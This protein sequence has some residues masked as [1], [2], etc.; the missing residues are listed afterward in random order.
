LTPVGSEAY[1]REVR[2]AR[3]NLLYA[4]PVPLLVGLALRSWRLIP[5]DTAE[6]LAHTVTRPPLYPIFL[7]LMR[8][9][10][11]SHF[12]AGTAVVQQ[13]LGAGAAYWLA[14]RMSTRLELGRA[15]LALYYALLLPGVDLALVIG[16]ESISYSLFL[17]MSA[18]F[19]DA[20]YEPTTRRL[21]MPLVFA[22]LAIMTRA[23]FLFTLPVLA[24]GLLFAARQRSG[25]ATAMLILYAVGLLAAEN[26]AVKA[27]NYATNR[28]F[29]AAPVTGIQLLTM[30]TYVL[31]HDDLSLFA[32][33]DDRRYMSTV[34]QL[35]S[36]HRLLYENKPSGD[37][38]T[39]H[40]Y[41]SYAFICYDVLADTWA[42]QFA[43]RRF[44]RELQGRSLTPDQLVALDRYM[45]HLSSILVRHHPIRYATLV[46]KCWY[47]YSGLF[48]LFVTVAFVIALVRILQTGGREWTMLAFAYALWAANS[49]LVC[50]V[51]AIMWRYTCY[52]DTLLFTTMVALLLRLSRPTPAT[53]RA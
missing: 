52:T 14:Q 27:Y 29:A 31:R 21:L 20:I 46:M 36:D 12:M 26:V 41:E 33:P 50:L 3:F 25:K 5:H 53:A 48:G 11:R 37:P 9:A 24:L 38:T 17:L 8:L 13:L 28:Q 2:K 1:R 47:Q 39:H 22:L 32:A 51:E 45:L 19:V 10:F 18:A 40:L 34:F 30:N 44:D 6:Y 42:Q 49:L 15:A 7:D 23:Q 4:L 35:A 16:S 43:G